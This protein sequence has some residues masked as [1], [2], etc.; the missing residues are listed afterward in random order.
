M[1]GRADTAGA[2]S[3]ALARCRGVL[4]LLQQFLLLL[5]A[6]LVDVAHQFCHYIRFTVEKGN[7]YL[8]LLPDTFQ[9]LVIRCVTA[10]FVVRHTAAGGAG[11]NP[12]AHTQL[13]LADALRGARL[14]ES[15]GNGSALVQNV[16]IFSVSGA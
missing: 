11:L 12:Q 16:S 13:F 14:Q 7:R 15:H 9:E 8:Q 2:L 5:G 3:V 4:Q 10:F 6:E 1:C